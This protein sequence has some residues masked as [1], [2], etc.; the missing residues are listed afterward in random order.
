MGRRVENRSEEGRIEAGLG[1]LM[2]IVQMDD[3]KLSPLLL[4]EISQ[5]GKVH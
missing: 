4:I 3:L 2:H 5:H 1:R